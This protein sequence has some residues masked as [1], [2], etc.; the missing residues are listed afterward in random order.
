MLNFI[1]FLV[2]IM[3]LTC[4]TQTYA[5]TRARRIFTY[6]HDTA[7][8]SGFVIIFIL[9]LFVNTGLI[10]MTVRGIGF[11]GVD[12][13][14]RQVMSIVYFSL[15]TGI[16]W[17]SFVLL[18]SQL[19]EKYYSRA[20]ELGN[21]SPGSSSTVSDGNFPEK[22]GAHV[23]RRVFLKWTAAAGFVSAGGIGAVGLAEAYGQ[24]SKEEFDV[25]HP[26]LWGLSSSLKVIQITDLHYGWFFGDEQLERLVKNINSLDADI[27]VITG[28]LFHSPYTPVETA[29]PILKKLK[30]R[31]LGNYAILG[32]HEYFVGYRRSIRAIRAAGLTH[33]GDDWITLRKDSATI[34]LGCLDDPLRDWT[35]DKDWDLI[36]NFKSKM[37][38]GQGLKFVLC[39][40]PA[41]LPLASRA[42]FDLTLSG[43]VHG[44]QMIVPIPGT[45][46]EFSPARIKSKYT[47]GWYADGSSKMYLNRGAGMI[48]VPWRINCPPEISVFN[49]KHGE[50]Y[51]IVGDDNKIKRSV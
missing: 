30:K 11:G 41:V 49:L 43:H 16:A 39:H 40:R 32:N 20:P 17:F 48:Y 25:Y 45:D 31:P 4:L 13:E 8:V 6:S 38:R 7:V 22:C 34:D 44:G 37:P 1:I 10:A 36:K 29:I 28:D 23:S 33:F 42:G 14:I 27:F 47:H 12:S 19:L 35:F 5:L 18:F 9:V 24:F 51:A 2:T 26:S 21:K 3:L 46:L 50:K 15:V